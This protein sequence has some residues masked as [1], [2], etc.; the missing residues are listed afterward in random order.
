MCSSS[1]VISFKFDV[2]IQ[3]CF[4]INS[5]VVRSI[6]F[7]LDHIPATAIELMLPA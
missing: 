3:V 7:E 2:I 4:W 5:Q 6:V 1:A